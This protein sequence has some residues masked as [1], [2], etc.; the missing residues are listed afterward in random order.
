MRIVPPKFRFFVISVHLLS[1]A[2]LYLSS[3]ISRYN[4][5]EK[6]NKLLNR[7][8]KKFLSL[9]NTSSG[10]PNLVLINFNFQPKPSFTVTHALFASFKLHDKSI[11]RV[12]KFAHLSSFHTRSRHVISEKIYQSFVS[13]QAVVISS[14]KK[15]DTLVLFIEVWLN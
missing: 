12:L 14:R 5:R 3:G 13:N 10:T 8:I 6:C 7:T 1:C 9:R 11:R 15:E 2:V 4:L